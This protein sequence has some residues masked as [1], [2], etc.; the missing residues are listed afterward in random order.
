MDDEHWKVLAEIDEQLDR[1]AELLK[2]IM[3]TYERHCTRCQ[4]RG[5]YTPELTRMLVE[6]DTCV[7]D[8]V[9]P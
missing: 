5:Y 6:C 7:R 3:Q 2:R 9:R 1:T 4:G 8:E